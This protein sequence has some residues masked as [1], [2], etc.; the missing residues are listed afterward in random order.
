[1]KCRP[2]TEVVGVENYKRIFIPSNIWFGFS[3]LDEGKNLILSISD[4]P[5]EQN[6][7]MRRSI[8]QIAYGW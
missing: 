3:G 5:H 1:M 7:V 4:L 6:E 8:D 2:R